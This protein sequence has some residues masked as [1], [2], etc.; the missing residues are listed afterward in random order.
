KLIGTAMLAAL[1]ATSAF[2]E[3]SMG[4]WVRTVVAP[5][6]G[7]GD[8]V[9]AGWQNSWGWGVRAARISFNWTSDDEKVGMMYDIF[10]DNFKPVIGDYAAGW[11][12]PA[13]WV[14]FMVGKIDN[15]YTMR[16]D[17]CYG[18]WDWIRPGN[19]VHDDEGITFELGGTTGLQVE[20]FP[21]E[22]LQI[23]A[24]LPLPVAET[25]TITLT[26]RNE[27]KDGKTETANFTEGS[28]ITTYGEAYKLYGNGTVAVGYTIGDIGTIKA[29]FLGSYN[30]NGSGRAKKEYGDV[31]VAFDLTAVENMFL[32][33]GV[34]I[35]VAE[36]IK[37]GERQVLPSL[38]F[39]Y[40]IL[41]NFRIAL[42]AAANI[43]KTYDPIISAGV[44]IN[45]GFT[46]T[47]GLVADFRYLGD[48]EADK[49]QLSFMVGI[50]YNFS[51]NGQLGIGFQGT[52]EGKG[53]SGGFDPYK[54]DSFC[55][56][57]PVKFGYWF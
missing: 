41:D 5:V 7:N 8:D 16:S 15:G 10:G 47:L 20:L 21:V 48:L 55:W 28:S 27:S 22:G 45:Y 25:K 4:A 36:D 23:L 17:V 26:D 30:E 19:W 50:D 14:K 1:L 12:K 13:D 31:N 49:T 56:A 3:L 44:G 29:A 42:T 54:G 52:T 57:V 34:R 43:R 39:S 6:A 24:R 46:D 11:W 37:E 9:L 38:G 35:L 32:T 33:L 18:S 40:Q 53:F 51:G 2:A